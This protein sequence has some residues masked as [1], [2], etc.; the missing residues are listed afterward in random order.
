MGSECKQKEVGELLAKKIV[1]GQE[2]W[3]E[4]DTEINVEGYK[5]FGKPRSNKNSQRG[6]G[7]YYVNAWKV[8]LN[9]FLV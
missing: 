4:E 3:K 9:L 6:V 7:F 8:R 2:S 5:W 1:A